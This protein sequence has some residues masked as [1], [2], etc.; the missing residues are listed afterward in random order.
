M[1]QEPRHQL[2]KH[3]PNS[4][5]RPPPKKN[6]CGMGFKCVIHLP[7]REPSRDLT[8]TGG[9]EWLGEQGCEAEDQG[10]C[11]AEACQKL[12]CLWEV[13][14]AIGDG[15]RETT[16]FGTRKLSLPTSAN[17]VDQLGAVK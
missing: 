3:P 10:S 17:P 12:G 9:G 11:K 2:F 13:R 5:P 1:K 8:D 14:G 15:V 6:R 16:T 7:E 4:T